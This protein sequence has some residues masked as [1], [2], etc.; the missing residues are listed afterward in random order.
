[1]FVEDEPDLYEILSVLFEL[2]GHD[3]I[4][5]QTGE[6]AVDWLQLVEEEGSTED[7]P[8]LALLDIRLPGE[9]DGIEICKQIRQNRLL[10]NI[11]VILATAYRLTHKQIEQIMADTQAD[12]LLHK[13][14]PSAAEFHSMLDRLIAQKNGR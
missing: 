14:L 7:L 3:I 6:D 11:P 9:I 4:A 1:M 2:W 13:P 8:E 10:A 12:L 5:F